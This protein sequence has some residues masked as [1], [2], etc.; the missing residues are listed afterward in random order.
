[1]LLATVAGASTQLLHTPGKGTGARFRECLVSFFPWDIDPPR[2]VSNEEAAKILY[3]VFRNPMVHFLGLNKATDPIVKIGH[4]FRGTDDAE[5]RVEQLERLTVKPYSDPCLVVTP[6]KRVLWLDPFYW[7]VRRLVERWSRDADQWRKRIR[8]SQI[9]P[10]D[11][12]AIQANKNPL[13]AIAGEGVSSKESFGHCGKGAWNLFETS[14]SRRLVLS[15]LPRHAAGGAVG[16]AQRV[17]AGEVAAGDVE[18]R[19]MRRGGDRHRQAR[20]DRDAALET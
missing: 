13:A 5:Q 17:D 12:G 11:D 14:C 15:P 10:S 1:V 4:V 2:G 3:D 19:A 20:R 8:S 6:E 16:F 18:R 7:G 9:L